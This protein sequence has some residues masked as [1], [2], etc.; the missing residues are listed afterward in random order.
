MSSLRRR[1]AGVARRVC[2]GALAREPSDCRMGA[3]R[4][5]RSDSLGRV[6][7]AIERCDDPVGSRAVLDPMRERG[8]NVVRGIVGRRGQSEHAADRIRSETQAAM[9]HARRHEQPIK[10]LRLLDPARFGGDLLVIV[11]RAR[12]G[13][14]CIVPAMILDQLAARVAEGAADPGSARRALARSFPGPARR[15]STGL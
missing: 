1:G 7:V 14:R 5:L 10:G 15:S 3:P 11:D 13:D 6:V 2:T 4:T 8:D 12:R 9:L